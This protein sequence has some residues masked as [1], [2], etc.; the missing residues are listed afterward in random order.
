MI[1]FSL[2]CFHAC[3]E[4]KLTKGEGTEVI[5]NMWQKIHCGRTN[6]L[7]CYDFIGLER[8]WEPQGGI[9]KR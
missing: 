7:Y 8:K 6:F 9:L 4:K 2:G 5:S 1:R 3:L